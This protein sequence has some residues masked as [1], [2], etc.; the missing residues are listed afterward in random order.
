M[1]NAKEGIYLIIILLLLSGILY[2]S[3]SNDNKLKEL[4]QTI[5]KMK[6]FV[7]NLDK[8]IYRWNLIKYAYPST[9][10]V[11]IPIERF[12]AIKGKEVDIDI[13]LNKDGIAELKQVEKDGYRTRHYQL[14]RGGIGC[15]LSHYTLAKQLI[16]DKDNEIYLI[17]E[18]DAGLPKSPLKSINEYLE[19]S[20]RDW[21]IILFGTH[22]VLGL[23]L[24][25]FV[26][27]SAF[28]GLY[29]YIINK[30]GAKKLVDSVNETKID[31]QLDTYMA[32][33][34]QTGKL[35]IYATKK[36]II[37]DNNQSNQ[38]DIQIQLIEQKNVDPYIYKGF[39]C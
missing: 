9:D 29:G 30:R 8:N 21:D 34:A 37:V 6:C 20:P 23:P 27:V 31:A 12:S 35:N 4:F 3:A 13:W 33:M 11:D 1:L 14:T 5:P 16:D 26:K 10:L 22:R 38:T 2:F 15:F 24:T 17:L 25:N 18:D 32:W 7:I 28:W 19:I 39:N 36:H